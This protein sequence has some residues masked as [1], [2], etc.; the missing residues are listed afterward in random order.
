MKRAKAVVEN[1]E[2]VTS[3]WP[4]DSKHIPGLIKLALYDIVILCGEFV[5][6]KEKK[7][8]V[9]RLLVDNSTSICRERREELL[10]ETLTRV[11]KFA[12]I[13]N[14]TGIFLRFLHDFLKDC[15]LD[16]LTTE[17]IKVVVDNIKYSCGTKLGTKL[18]EKVVVPM[19]IQRA[20]KLEKPLV[21]VIITD[22]RVRVHDPLSSGELLGILPCTEWLTIYLA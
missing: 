13:L 2:K 12:T 6:S 5:S 7:E 8:K 18:K 10:K 20:E 11:V 22:G 15:E 21:V 16:N 3:K 14:K 1:V 4:V 9:L 17:R 19:V